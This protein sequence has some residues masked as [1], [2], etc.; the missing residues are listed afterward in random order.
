MPNRTNFLD[1][2]YTKKVT[3]VENRYQYKNQSQ[4]DSH[5]Y[6]AN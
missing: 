4:L 6:K 2:Q 1:K 5:G 3:N